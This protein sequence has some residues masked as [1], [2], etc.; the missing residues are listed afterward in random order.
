MGLRTLKSTIAD[1]ARIY[2][3]LHP[4]K[5]LTKRELQMIFKNMTAITLAAVLSAGLVAPVLAQDMKMGLDAIAE[6]QNL[7]KASGGL[8][9][10]AAT[11]NPVTTGEGLVAN[12][13][14]LKDLWGKDTMEGGE[15]EALPAIWNAD[16]SV[17]EGFQVAMNNAMTAAQGV[18]AAAQSGDGAAFGASLK[19]M[20][21]TCGACHGTYRKKD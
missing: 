9:K 5:I 7:M 3:A 13:T 21:G 20:G 17:S 15:T 14:A 10:G 2:R 11:A 12:Y 4:T 18:L 6:R 8:M 19:A 1:F 16:G